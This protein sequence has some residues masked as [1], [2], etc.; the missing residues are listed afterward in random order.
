MTTPFIWQFQLHAQD[1]P[2]WLN[3]DSDTENIAVAPVT[4]EQRFFWPSEHSIILHGLSNE[5]MQLS[6]YVFDAK[7]DSY[8]ILDDERN[9][10][11]R[12]KKL[13]YKPMLEAKEHCMA[14]A[15][16][17]KFHFIN[18]KAAIENL[19]GIPS[20]PVL[21]LKEDMSAWLKTRF[22]VCD[23]KK[24]SLKLLIGID[25][26]SIELSRLQVAQ[27]F[28][29]SLVIEASTPHRVNQCVAALGIDDVP[30]GYV[31]FLKGVK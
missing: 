1:K 5:Q 2:F 6:S 8:L 14:F 31:S 23:V 3:W 15:E 26:A 25:D 18:D 17:Q 9:I 29:Y 7:T 30:T 20:L 24:E 16:K 13:H 10:K 22:R 27:S 12:K 4:Y 19:L 11:F 28:F 21:T